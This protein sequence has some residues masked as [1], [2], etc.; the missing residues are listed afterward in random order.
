LRQTY[1]RPPKR[2]SRRRV[3]RYLYE[4]AHDLFGE[5]GPLRR[6]MRLR[7]RAR[8]DAVRIMANPIVIASEAKQSRVKGTCQIW[9]A[10]SAVAD[11]Q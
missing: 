7:R 6:I 8:F 11:S 1:L 10:S 4:L 3:A 5:P 9:I 2:A